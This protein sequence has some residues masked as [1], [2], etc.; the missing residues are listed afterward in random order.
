MLLAYAHHVSETKLDFWPVDS[1]KQRR[2]CCIR[3]LGDGLDG[4]VVCELAPFARVGD[5][6]AAQGKIEKHS[7]SLCLVEKC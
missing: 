3:F 6:L 4:D 2:N 1:V 7:S 5:F